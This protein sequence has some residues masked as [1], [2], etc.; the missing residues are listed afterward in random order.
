MHPSEDR[1]QK[2]E[3]ID[4]PRKRQADLRWADQEEDEDEYVW[5]KGQWCPPGLR[6]SQKRRVPLLRNRELRQA[7]TQMRQVWRPKDK[8]KGSNRTALTCMVYF[9]PSEFMAPANQVV[10]EEMSLDDEQLGGLMA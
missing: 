8:P 5:Q 7:G 1:W 10:Q 9:L 2:I 4:H 6:K 3:I